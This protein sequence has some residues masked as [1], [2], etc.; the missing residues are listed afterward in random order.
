MDN[1]FDFLNNG[2]GITV[3][4]LTLLGLGGSSYAVHN[5]LKK[6]KTKNAFLITK[7]LFR[8]KVIPT[9]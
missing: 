9:T 5:R 2:L 4:I 3:S 6:R 1:V 7:T 8:V